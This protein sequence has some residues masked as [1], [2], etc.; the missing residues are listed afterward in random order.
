M[1]GTDVEPVSLVGGDEDGGGGLVADCAGFGVGGG[2]EAAVVGV[3]EHVCCG[4][5]WLVGGGEVVCIGRFRGFV[6]RVRTWCSYEELRRLYVHES[7]A[8]WI[9]VSY[10]CY[11]KCAGAMYTA[12]YLSKRSSF[13]AKA[14]YLSM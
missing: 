1:R 12:S 4:G 3:L 8:L 11:G 6:S 2:G 9:N 14:Q 13:V 10:A 7:R 5:L